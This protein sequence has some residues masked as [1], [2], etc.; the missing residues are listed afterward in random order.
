MNNFRILA[1]LLSGL[2]LVIVLAV[3]HATH[4]VGSVALA[5][6]GLR[7]SARC[8]QFDAEAQEECYRLSIPDLYPTYDV[9][10]LFR[11]LEFGQR[12]DSR[13]A[14][15][16]F[17]AHRIGEVAVA[18]NPTLWP[19][20]IGY[21]SGIGLCSYGYVHGVT[22]AAYTHEGLTDEEVARE[23]P[24]FQE[25]CAHGGQN[26]QEGCIHAL[27]HMM[28]YI[29][30]GDITRAL[31]FCDEATRL[32]NYGADGPFTAERR[33]YTGVMMM[34]FFSFIDPDWEESTRYTLTREN[35]RAFCEDLKRDAYVGACLRA[36][37]PL[38]AEDV[39]Q[40]GGVDRFCENQPNDIETTW[41]YGKLFVALGWLNVNDPDTMFRQCE[42]TTEEWRSSCYI[43][44]TKEYVAEGAGA[45]AMPKA[46]ALC[47]RATDLHVREQCLRM[48][49]QSGARYE[50]QGDGR[51]RF[52]AP[53]PEPWYA[54]CLDREDA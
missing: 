40:D 51:Q 2:A 19:E 43:H 32:L 26:L 25:A 46:T 28:Y 5:F 47:L 34:P 35:V 54:Q 36:S 48:L 14:D 18:D 9:P 50:R 16:H 45:R 31:P 38:F 24:K 39:Q 15:C 10:E 27:G 22:I 44:A 13:L 41:C 4:T 21:E 52:C 8:V 7:M 12:I 3:V 30:G 29:A 6:E 11:L 33:C 42:A 53:L 49:A 23:M 20:L 17:I 1:V 37:W